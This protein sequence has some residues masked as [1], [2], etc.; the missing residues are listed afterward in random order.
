MGPLV[1]YLCPE[2]RTVPSYLF[3]E[4]VSKVEQLV[5]VL[6]VT[7][8]S[9]FE[10]CWDVLT[11]GLHLRYIFLSASGLRGYPDTGEI[12]GASRQNSQSSNIPTR[13]KMAANGH[14]EDYDEL[15]DFASPVISPVSG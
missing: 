15:L 6:C 10:S 12:T 8:G 2:G 13:L 4:R 14:A 11:I 9:H 3:R 1:Q 7:V 5:V